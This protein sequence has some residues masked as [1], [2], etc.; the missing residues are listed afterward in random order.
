M[1]MTTVTKK[2]KPHPIA[3]KRRRRLS[4]TIRAAYPGDEYSNSEVNRRIIVVTANHR[5]ISE[6][7]KG[8]IMFSPYKFKHSVDAAVTSRQGLLFNNNCFTR[9]LGKRRRN[10][11]NNGA[12]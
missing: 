5:L 4:S 10:S 7:D 2:P 12:T 6:T 11:T 8:K 1:R 3:E 9:S